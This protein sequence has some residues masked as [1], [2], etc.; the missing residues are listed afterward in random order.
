MRGKLIML[1]EKL[2]SI[3]DS[4][5]TKS[6]RYFTFFIHSLIILSLI[7][8]SLETL[9]DL[10]VQWRGILSTLEIF[11]VTIFT[12]EY[13]LHLYLAKKRIRFI[14]SFYGII[15]LLAVLPFYLTGGLDLIGLRIFRILRLMKIFKLFRYNKAMSRFQRAFEIAKEELIIFGFIALVMFY[16]SAVGIY[17]FENPAQPEAFKSV[18]HSLWW[19]LITLTTVGYGDMFPITAGGKIF[20]F[21]VLSTGLGVVAVPTGLISSAL[22]QARQEEKTQL[23]SDKMEHEQANKQDDTR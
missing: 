13:L 16:F 23:E 18:F 17:Y 2:R 9:P 15:D 7:T 4:T 11:I 1:K 6:G 10:S 20:T 3:F 8:F 22:Y 5:A 21:F 19:A 14:F 12:I